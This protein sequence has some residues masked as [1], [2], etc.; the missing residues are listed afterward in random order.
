MKRIALHILYIMMA[1]AVV[2]GLDSCKSVKLKDADE[3]LE[4]GE[5]NDAAKTYRKIYNR[6]TKR[7]DR[8]LRGEVAYKLAECHRRLN[9]ASRAAASY[10]NA[11]RYQYPDSM[12]YYW[13]VPH[14]GTGSGRAGHGPCGY[15]HVQH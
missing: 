9:Q 12:A 7:E 8:P 11:I 5:F 15:A 1:F 3:Q 10:Q 14:S 6:L 13:V 2:A 4:R